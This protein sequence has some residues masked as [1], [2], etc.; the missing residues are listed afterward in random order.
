VEWQIESGIAGIVVSGTTGESATLSVE[1]KIELVKVI[2]RQAAG[3]IKIIVG[4]GSNDT[5]KSIEFSQQ[6]RE[7][8]VDAAL[9]VAPYYNKPTQEG[10]Y[11]HFKTLAIEGGLPLILYNVP[12][13]T[14][15]DIQAR[16]VARL[17]ELEE[18]IGIKE[19]SGLAE[20]LLELA[21]LSGPGFSLLTG[22][23]HLICFCMAAGGKG[24]ISASANVIPQKIV[25]IVKAGLAGDSALC[26]K[27]QL[28]AF[29][30]IKA[31]F[32]ET[33]PCPAKTALQIMG[34]IGSDE[35]RLPLV[36]VSSETRL[37]LEG[38]LRNNG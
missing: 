6:V 29:P 11:Q 37:V 5:L 25:N 12:S 15:V 30:L 27:E 38:M 2:S 31:L 21:P 14:S 23:D 22:D 24:A 9:A 19:S 10:L 34:R 3:R 18:V 8:G 1:E 28:D 33:N 13:R 20:R 35:V 4:T 17:A 26:L 32:L 36:A 7:L 16:T